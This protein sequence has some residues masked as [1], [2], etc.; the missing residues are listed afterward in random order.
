MPGARKSPRDSTLSRGFFA[1]QPSKDLTTALTWDILYGDGVV[2]SENQSGQMTSY[3]YG[4]ERISAKTGSTRTEYVYDGRGSVAAEVSYNNAW[5]GTWDRAYTRLVRWKHISGGGE[6]MGKKLVVKKESIHDFIF[7]QYKP[8]RLRLLIEWFFLMAVV[9]LFT[10][11]FAKES[12]FAFFTTVGG[13]ICALI[14]I[15]VFSILHDSPPKKFVIDGVGFLYMAIIFNVGASQIIGSGSNKL[16]SVF[17]LF[18]LLLCAVGFIF[19]AISNIKKDKYNNTSS[20]S[21]LLPL[22]GVI[23]GRLLATAFLPHVPS[24]TLEIVMGYFILLLSLLFISTCIV[25]FLKLYYYF[26]VEVRGGTYGTGVGS[27]SHE[28]NDN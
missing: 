24:D 25:T 9:C 26:T 4:L 7:Y 3:T 21:K 12:W 2:I 15:I 11:H 8:A 5:Y 28:E 1:P 19:I 22:I 27:P 17:F 13:C 23:V 14:I 20:T 16:L 18:L 6:S 10:S